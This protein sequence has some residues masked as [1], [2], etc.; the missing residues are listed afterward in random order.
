MNCVV[1][2]IVKG[3]SEPVKGLTST[4]KHL[5][6]QTNLEIQFEKKD[7]ASLDFFNSLT[8]D[9]MV[10]GLT[11]API[12]PLTFVVGEAPAIGRLHNR[13]RKSMSRMLIQTEEIDWDTASGILEFNVENGIGSDLPPLVELVTRLIFRSTLKTSHT[14]HDLTL[15][16]LKQA[17]GL[18]QDSKDGVEEA[19]QVISWMNTRELVTAEA[20]KA[21][22]A[23]EAKAKREAKAKAAK[24]KKEAEA[25]VEAAAEKKEEVVEKAKAKASKAKA[26][27]AKAAKTKPKT[28]ELVPEEDPQ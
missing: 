5:K 6:T 24:A 10:L 27:K 23:A 12:G 17:C 20:E 3:K 15:F 11:E 19:D 14:R 21:A 2:L 13:A 4:V 18:V 22:K 1:S 9:I 26:A 7:R 8:E 16:D 28:A 25:K